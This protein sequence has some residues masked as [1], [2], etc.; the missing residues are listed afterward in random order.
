MR[1]SAIVITAVALSVIA[2]GVRASGVTVEQ[3][4]QHFSEKSAALKPGEAMVISNQGRW[5]R[6]RGW[7]DGRAPKETR[8]DGRWHES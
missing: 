7:W 3:S 2:A 8:T 1:V 5:Y 4:G 6:A